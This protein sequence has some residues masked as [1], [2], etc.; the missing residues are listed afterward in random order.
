MDN[1]RGQESRKGQPHNNA[2]GSRDRNQPPTG[3]EGMNYEQKRRPYINGQD[4]DKNNGKKPRW[5]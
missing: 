3:F 2:T 1:M 4:D 5:P